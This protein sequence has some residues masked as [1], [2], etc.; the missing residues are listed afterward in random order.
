MGNAATRMNEPQETI[1]QYSWKKKITSIFFF[2]VF[3]LLVIFFTFLI[4]SAKS[5]KNFG[6][7]RD[8]YRVSLMSVIL[9]QWIKH[10]INKY[11]IQIYAHKLTDLLSLK[12]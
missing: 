1:P 10:A 4:K 5:N 3:M 8:Y 12:S 11:I 2:R 7:I 6:Q 9:R